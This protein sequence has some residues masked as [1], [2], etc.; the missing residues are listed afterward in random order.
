MFCPNCGNNCGNANFCASCG[1]KLPQAA[2]LAVQ[3]GEWKVGM[4]CPN[5]GGTQ[6]DG[7]KCAFCGSQLVVNVNPAEDTV[8]IPYG[9]YKGVHSY[10]ELKEDHLVISTWFFWAKRDKKM[11][12]VSYPDLKRVILHKG[13]G[14]Y[15]GGYL[16]IRWGDNIH[17]PTPNSDR[18]ASGDFATVHFCSHEL[19]VYEQIYRAL[20]TIIDHNERA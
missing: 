2:A 17:I 10:L 3:S 20:K 12:C 19:E 5:C 1:T 6:L 13:V 16:S 7:Q 9:Y 14:K 18:E 8:P 4:P 15:D 11:F